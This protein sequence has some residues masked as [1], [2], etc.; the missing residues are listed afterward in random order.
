MISSLGCVY[1]VISTGKSQSID[2]IHDMGN[3]YNINKII[4]YER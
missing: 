4:H 2:P 1:A 3:L